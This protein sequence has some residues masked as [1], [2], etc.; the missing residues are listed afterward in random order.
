[1]FHM[2]GVFAEFEHALQSF[3]VVDGKPARS[4]SDRAASRRV[5]R[6]GCGSFHSSAAPARS[7]KTFASMGKTDAILKRNVDAFAA[8]RWRR[9]VQ[10]K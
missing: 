3:H 4:S 1:M 10:P 7:V 9:E 6:F 5:V 2:I 8:A